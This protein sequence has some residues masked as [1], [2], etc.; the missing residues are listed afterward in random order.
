MRVM[1]GTSRLPDPRGNRNIEM[2]FNFIS[3]YGKFS[4]KEQ[5]GAKMPTG[6]SSLDPVFEGGI[7]PGSVILLLSD[8]G[9]GSNEFAYSSILNLALMNKEEGPGLVMPKEITYVTF[10]KMKDDIRSE[11][12]RSFNPDL[13]AGLEK[14][15]FEDLSGLYFDS[16]VVPVEWYAKS[17]V[18]E[19]MQKRS[20]RDNAL[21]QL[22]STFNSIEE[23][24]LVVIDSLTDLGTQVAASSRWNDLVAFL[25]GLQR[26]CKQRNITVY[27][28][29]ARGILDIQQELE[30]SDT[31][32]AVLLF[33][34]EETSGA[35]RQRVMYVEKF[36]GIM[37]HLEDRD[38]VKFSVRISS[39][40]GFE[41]SNIRVV[42]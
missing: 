18:L 15:R 28:M 32:D 3:S 19:R 23:D 21:S 20:G 38:L 41:V 12:W 14:I 4:M 30:I 26:I 29:L 16:S 10:T 42:I 9:A 2:V 27:I 11:I 34:W 13:A 33:R 1:T 5:A 40:G 24:S 37:P 7:P 6:I 25:R 39:T 31:S 8:V 22:A 35:R 17:D 36:R